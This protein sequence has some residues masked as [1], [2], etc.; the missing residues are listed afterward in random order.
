MRRQIRDTIAHQRGAEEPK[1]AFKINETDNIMDY[2]KNL[3]NSSPPVKYEAGYYVSY[4]KW[5]IE[6]MKNTNPDLE[7]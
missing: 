1:H 4:W 5:Q 2:R 3:T 7:I 6:K